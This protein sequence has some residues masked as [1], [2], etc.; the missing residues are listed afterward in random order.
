MDNNFCSHDVF[1]ELGHHLLNK[2]VGVNMFTLM[3]RLDVRKLHD[4]TW[5]QEKSEPVVVFCWCWN[6]NQRRK[7][8]DGIFLYTRPHLGIYLK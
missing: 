8:I 5:V 2:Y 1:I 4:I 3:K 6:L 7:D